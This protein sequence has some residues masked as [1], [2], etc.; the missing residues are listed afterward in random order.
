MI[1]VSRRISSKRI[2]NVNYEIVSRFN[3]DNDIFYKVGEMIK[4]DFSSVGFNGISAENS[5][6]SGMDKEKL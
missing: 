4:K 5:L 2:K 6:K 3:G 1:K